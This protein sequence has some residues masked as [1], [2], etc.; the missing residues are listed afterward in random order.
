MIINYLDLLFA[1]RYAAL[2]IR[3]T[4]EPMEHGY[5]FS[6]DAGEYRLCI[7]QGKATPA[8]CAEAVSYLGIL[9]AHVGNLTDYQ[10]DKLNEWTYACITT[11]LERFDAWEHQPN[12]QCLN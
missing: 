9:I 2:T 3:V 10:W 1:C 7:E 4:D 8:L 11:A 12:A 5:Q 6:G